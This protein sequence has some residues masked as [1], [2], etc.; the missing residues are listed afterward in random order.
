MLRR[1]NNKITAMAHRD[2]PQLGGL[3]TLAEIRDI[4]P[5]KR[6][7]NGEVVR[8]TERKAGERWL[9]MSDFTEEVEIFDEAN[10]TA[11]PRPENL[12]GQLY[13]LFSGGGGDLVA[14]LQAHKGELP[15]LKLSLCKRVRTEL[16]K[17]NVDQSAAAQLEALQ[18]AVLKTP[19]LE[20]CGDGTAVRRPVS[21][22]G[23]IG[24]GGAQTVEM[25][26][27]FPALLLRAAGGPPT[28]LRLP[29][30]S[31]YLHT[32]AEVLGAP[33]VC[34]RLLRRNKALESWLPPEQP[35]LYEAVCDASASRA[36]NALASRLCGM[37]LR[38][39]VLL[40]AVGVDDRGCLLWHEEGGRCP[41]LRTLCG[42]L[43]RD[44][45]G[46]AGYLAY[47]WGMPLLASWAVPR[48]EAR[49]PKG[50]HTKENSKAALNEWCMRVTG[51]TSYTN[52]MSHFGAKITYDGESGCW[53][54]VG[55]VT[56]QGWPAGAPLPPGARVRDEDEDSEDGADAGEGGH[57]GSEDGGS[58][59]GGGQISACD[60]SLASASTGVCIELTTR[61]CGRK[62]MGNNKRA[63]GTG[64]Q[65][66][67]VVC[68]E[69]A[70]IALLMQAL[71]Q[72]QDLETAAASAAGCS[73][74]LLASASPSL[75]AFPLP[76]PLQFD[77]ASSDSSV[78]APSA[79]AA[80]ATPG[81][82]PLRGSGA[83]M[84]FGA[85]VAGQTAGAAN[86]KPDSQP[87]GAGDAAAPDAPP[88]G[89][90]Y[91][92]DGTRLVCSLRLCLLHGSDGAVGG[93]SANELVR[94]AEELAVAAEEVIE[95]VEQVEVLLGGRVVA[96]V[97]EDALRATAAGG[98][99]RCLVLRGRLLGEPCTLRLQLT[100]HSASPAVEVPTVLGGGGTGSHGKERTDY[101]L[102]FVHSTS[103]ASVAD[104]GCGEGKLISALLRTRTAAGS[105][106]RVAGVDAAPSGAVLRLAE[107]RIEQALRE[108]TAAG[109]A[110]ADGAPG[111]T[112]GSG[113]G[114][115][116]LDGAAPP[117]PLPRVELWRGSLGGVC[118]SHE[119]VLLVE[120]IEHLDDPK[121]ELRRFL[122][123]NAPQRMLLT[124]PNKE[125]NLHWEKQPDDWLTQEPGKR[126]RPPHPTLRLRNPDHRFEF[127]RDEFR[128][129][130]TAIGKDYGYDVRMDGIGGGPMDE[131]PPPGEW[132]GA[133][134]ITQVAIF[135]RRAGM[136]APPA[137]DARVD[138]ST[139]E[140]VWPAPGVGGAAAVGA[141]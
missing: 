23:V 49:W 141:A 136:A 116:Q 8:L 61:P 139:A 112:D 15:L 107:R 123:R 73:A 113:T 1:S 21:P 70:A 65:E 20:L 29:C 7:R 129:W 85:G 127:T 119:L 77:P 72:R 60:T 4:L 135:E 89:A 125:Y 120:V 80:P 30:R 64:G 9:T 108:A 96:P 114:A 52:A 74:S 13:R 11:V 117:D 41:S 87:A 57:G 111:A 67:R 38:G 122:G 69:E 105:L 53:G 137:E 19:G 62:L 59:G 55:V 97:V 100:V 124:T 86:T 115:S 40:A 131:Y 16:N 95:Q 84:A 79:Q 90:E 24:T 12:P 130:A 47:C 37:Q 42:L 18:E 91:Y 27:T 36:H 51:Q 10:L 104:V 66:I 106:I 134:P 26:G 25:D 138:E 34:P 102:D 98:G 14:H 140:R 126:R 71:I 76:P 75:D 81:D 28:P 101:I 46:L 22:A 93:A 121:A 128:L 103:P 54:H 92:E 56:L 94:A 82:S 32:L 35:L 31:D 43:A 50:K 39:D 133:G 83:A 132:R 63:R 5:P 58:G 17:L 33:C 88:A 78:P 3:D 48:P 110:A 44:E 99:E 45:C 6:N 2:N 68:A 109:G 118:L